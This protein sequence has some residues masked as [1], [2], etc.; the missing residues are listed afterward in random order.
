MGIAI[1][2]SA[3]VA[4]ERRGHGLLDGLPDEPE[5]I[6]LP[7]L[8]A[9]E[10]WIGIELAESA[11]RRASRARKIQALL[12]V[13]VILPFDERIAPTY[14]R[15][16]AFLRNAGTPIPSNDLAIGSLAVHFGHDLL[17]GP[18]DEHHFRRIPD[19]TVRVLP[20]R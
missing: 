4:L 15:I 2:T 12:E 3:L 10:L 14:A 17:V 18:L 11:R 19:L 7:A 5:D 8:V 9:A 6:Y 20:A 13:A 16:Y 1:D